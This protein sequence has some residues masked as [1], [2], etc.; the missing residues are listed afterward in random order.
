MEWITHSAAKATDPAAIQPSNTLHALASSIFLHMRAPCLRFLSPKVFDLR[1][2]CMSFVL[3]AVHKD[4]S[5]TYNEASLPDFDSVLLIDDDSQSIS[6]IHPV[7]TLPDASSCRFCDGGKWH[8]GRDIIQLPGSR[9]TD[10]RTYLIVSY[11]TCHSK[12][13]YLHA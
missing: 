11:C 6:K 5:R 9:H 7:P 4:D 2:A 8:A 10:A 3:R 12:F 13:F 1:A